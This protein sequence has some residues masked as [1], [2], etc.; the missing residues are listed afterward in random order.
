[1]ALPESSQKPLP[2]TRT[3]G[4][5]ALR[6]KN[7]FSGILIAFA[8]SLLLVALLGLMFG[9]RIGYQNAQ[10]KSTLQ[11]RAGVAGEE[12]TASNVKALNHK[13]QALQ[14]SVNDAQQ[15]RDISLSNLE[16][17]R[18]S[19]DDLR[20][21]NLQLKQQ[22]EFLTSELAKRG[23]AGLQLIGIKI[24]PLSED[25]FEYRFDVGMVD[26]SGQSKKLS[27]KLTLLDDV[28]MVEVPIEPASYEINGVARVRGRFI[29][30]K[31]FTPKQ[32]KVV[33]TAAG[34]SIEQ[35]YDWSEGERLD[36]LPYSLAE[37]PN[38]DDRPIQNDNKTASTAGSTKS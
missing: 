24:A 3:I 19:L 29:M 16:G 13:I 28:N 15:E 1:M 2:T 38:T 21:T 31:D 7:E 12:L 36:N 14:N 37:T 35:I 23:G 18:E 26:R 17:L 10:G 22:N 11:A 4:Q 6:A 32:I 20:L 30:P 8:M 9:Q 33:L 27:P 25:A 34:Q 5:T